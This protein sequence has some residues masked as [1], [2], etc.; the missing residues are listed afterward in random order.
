VDLIAPDHPDEV[1]AGYGFYAKAR[2]R[3]ER[4]EECLDNRG[5]GPHR[6][7]HDRGPEKSGLTNNLVEFTVYDRR[8]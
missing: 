1:A 7:R 4:V 6:G 3:F 2:R 8:A 5:L